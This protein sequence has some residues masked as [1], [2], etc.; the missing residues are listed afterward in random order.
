MREFAKKI[1][2]LVEQVGKDLDW[3]ETDAVS[4]MGRARDLAQTVV[5]NLEAG[6]GETA[7]VALFKMAGALGEAAELVQPGGQHAAAVADVYDPRSSKVLEAAM[8]A[9]WNPKSDRATYLLMPART[10]AK[11]MGD[12]ERWF[13]DNLKN[14]DTMG[15]LSFAGMALGQAN[16]VLFGIRD[17]M[18][19]LASRAHDAA[20]ESA[21]VGSGMFPVLDR[22]GVKGTMR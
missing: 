6:N 10:M 13:A 20:E 5:R 18:R 14:G 7:V 15:A 17:M 9:L 2:N 12:A 1:D 4:Q 11:A 16:A 3:I 19:Y 22:M 21:H 8:E